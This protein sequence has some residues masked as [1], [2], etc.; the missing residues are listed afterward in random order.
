MRDI[1][2]A[3][4]CGIVCGWLDLFSY[5]LRQRFSQ[6]S[7]CCL[8][9]MLACL[10][11]K[12]GCDRELLRNLALMGGQSLVLAL[13]IMSGSAVT[14]HFLGRLF[15]QETA[16]L[17]GDGEEKGQVGRPDYTMTHKVGAAIVVG[18]V[19]G[20]LVLDTGARETLDK[21]LLSALTVMVFLAGI[22]IGTNRHLLA[23]ICT[24]RNIL[25]VLTLPLG[26]VA[27]TLLTAWLVGP[28]VGLSRYDALLVSASMGWYSLGSVVV[29]TMYNTT[30]G[31]ITFLT[32]MLRETLAIVLMPLFVR[33]DRLTAISLAGAAT[34][35]SGLP[36]VISNTNLQVGMIGFVSGLTLTLLVPPLLTFLLP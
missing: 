30:A 3:I 19:L 4:V 7:T 24:P 34:M 35:D 22:D 13:A 17:S 28:L 32:N 23:K 15:A 12:I 16:V 1:I 2:I 21:V 25:L 14:V 18:I 31:T 33:W 27:G 20:F 9:L 36:I 8:L 6:L 29:S 26:V 11:A 5:K 10:G